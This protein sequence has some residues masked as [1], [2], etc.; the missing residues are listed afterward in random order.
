MENIIVLNNRLKSSLAFCTAVACLCGGPLA[1]QEKLEIQVVKQDG[2]SETIEVDRNIEHLSANDRVLGR[3][4]TSIIL[5]EG[6]TNL[7]S[8]QF[9]DPISG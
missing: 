1:A 4:L 3:G 6:L 7:K 2:V 8:L 5:P 9:L